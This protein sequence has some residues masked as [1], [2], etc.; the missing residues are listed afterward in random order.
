[1]SFVVELLVEF[2][3]QGVIE[4]L[5]DLGAHS[6]K[7]D[8]KPPHPL[9]SVLAYVAIGAAL[10]W[11]SHLFFPH[12]LVSHPHAGIAN[13]VLTPVAVGLLM[14]AIGAW[15]SRRGSELV[16]L[17]KFAYGYAFAL[18]FALVRFWLGSTG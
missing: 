7:R 15:R 11:L 13:L 6:V 16:R 17:D 3:I 10:G 1:M 5:V 2:V 4:V 9:L 14:G 12:P 18:A 8:G